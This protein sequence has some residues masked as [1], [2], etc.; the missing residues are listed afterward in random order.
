METNRRKKILVVED[1]TELTKILKG[2]LEHFTYDVYVAS[3]GEEGLKKVK[4]VKPDLVVLDV[5]MPK[6]NGIAMCREI[7]KAPDT[8]HIPVIVLTGRGAGNDKKEAMD[9]GANGYMVKPFDLKLLAFKIK[10]LLEG[11][12]LV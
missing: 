9:A 5:M 4:E 6:M 1:E 8:K 2:L 11:E 7:R 3:D 10:G 12:K